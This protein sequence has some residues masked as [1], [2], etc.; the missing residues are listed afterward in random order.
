MKRPAFATIYL[1][2]MGTL[3][4]AQP[5]LSSGVS[6]GNAPGVFPT[7]LPTTHPRLDEYVLLNNEPFFPGGHQ[8]LQTFLENLNL[9]PEAARMSGIEGTVRVQFRV[10]PNG[11]LTDV[12]VVQSRS[13]LLDPAALEAVWRMPRWY[14]AHRD[15]VAVACLV[16]LPV[17][18]CID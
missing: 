11:R 15:G 9:Y 13:R 12:Q 5:P 18:F 2:V 10:L 1:T 14:P 8:A 3:V 16:D 17:R 4:F 7:D 6:G